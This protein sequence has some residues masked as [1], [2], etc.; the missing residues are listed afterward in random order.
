VNPPYAAVIA[1]EYAARSCLGATSMY[2]LLAC[3]VLACLAGCGTA[4]T[5]AAGPAGSAAALYV[6]YALLQ[7]ELERSPFERPLHLASR[8]RPGEM[9]GDV[10]AIL[11]HPFASVEGSLQGGQRWCDIM[12]LHLNIKAC[13]IA[14]EAQPSVLTVYIGKKFDDSAREAHKVVF[15][16]RVASVA[17]DYF[18]ISLS[19]DT[20]PFGTHDYRISV[21]AVPLADGR[22]FIHL[23]YAYRYGPA[24]KV[25]MQAYLQTVGAHKVGFTADGKQADGR[26]AFINGMRGALE[27]NVMRYYLAIEAYLAALEAPP[28]QQLEERLKDWFDATERYAQ[29]LHELD[30]DAYLEMKRRECA[31]PAPE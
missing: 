19:A 7:S 6:Q 13:R 10:H 30:E 15:V 4:R 28:D 16:Y 11:A 9:A 23:A 5:W 25:A 14:G 12:L 29:Q 21:E 3:L 22:T 20:G 8:E 2:R 17:P 24:A 27:R 31:A 1:G 18:R 26:P